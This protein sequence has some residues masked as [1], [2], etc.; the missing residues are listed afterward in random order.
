[1]CYIVFTA[2][3]CYRYFNNNISIYLFDLTTRI[4]LGK[5]KKN[6]EMNRVVTKW[7]ILLMKKK[8]NKGKKCKKIININLYNIEWK[9]KTLYS[10]FNF[11]L[12]KIN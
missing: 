12:K 8:K 4:N 5:K 2:V 3:V 11:H 1:M 10:R 9:E 6:I 7:K